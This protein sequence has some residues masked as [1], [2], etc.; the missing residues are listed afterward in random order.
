MLPEPRKMPK[1]ATKGD[2]MRKYTVGQYRGFPIQLSPLRDVMP[3]AET[4]PWLWF[5]FTPDKSDLVVAGVETQRELFKILR[6]IEKE[7]T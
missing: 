1:R 3:H 6:G 4:N 5:A 7:R 2:E